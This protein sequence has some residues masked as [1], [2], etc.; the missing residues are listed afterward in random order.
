M[1]S[2]LK[3]INGYFEHEISVKGN[4]ILVIAD[5]GVQQGARSG[6]W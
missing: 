1:L 6:L 5:M 4:L 3:M 2:N